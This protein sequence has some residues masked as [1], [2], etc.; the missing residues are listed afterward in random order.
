MRSWIISCVLIGA[1]SGSNESR[2]AD[3]AARIDALLRRPELRHALVGIE[4]YSLADRRVLYA[5][6]EHKLF[7]SG[8]VAKVVT[9]GAALELLGAERRFQTGLYGAGPVTPEGT[10]EGDLV[11]VA[12]GDPNLSNRVR[13]DG[14]LAFEDHDHAYGRVLE[15]ALV[16]GDPLQVI[17]DLAAQVSR[18]GVKRV[19]G[20]VL[21][22]VSLFPEGSREGGT[23]VVISPVCVNDNV[24]DVIVSPGTAAGEPASLRSSPATRYVAFESEVVT[25]AEGSATEVDLVLGHGADGR[26]VV[27]VRGTIGLGTKPRPFPF[28]VPEPSTF[29]AVVLEEALVEAGVTVAGGRSTDPPRWGDLATFYRP[30]RRLAE[31]VSPPL[32]ED[33]KVTLKVSQNLHAAM[34]PYLVGALVGG[35]HEDALE[36]GFARQRSFLAG[37]GLEL[38]AAAQ[39]DGAGAGAAFTPEFMVR[40]LAYMEGQ[41]EF[42]AFYDALPILGKDGSLADVLRGSPAAGRVHA[43]T[44]TL[45]AGDLLNRQYLVTGKGLAGYVETK[46]GERLAFAVFANHVPTGGEDFDAVERLGATL[47]EIAAAAVDARGSAPPRARPARPR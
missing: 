30:E 21:V 41:R 26:P 44:G 4:I 31:H 12:S 34:M 47:A 6:N 27:T 45:I 24:V 19:A 18:R 15:A 2:S 20:R 17:R 25:G 32:R 36:V 16:P 37:A 35:A 11:L 29:A 10:L 40:F 33:V 9:E 46:G 5:K 42:Q 22:D 1:L 38:S 43:K 28:A 7:V 23:G 39:S 14:T 8:S 13:E 3:L